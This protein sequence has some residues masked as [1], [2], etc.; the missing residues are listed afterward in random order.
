VNPALERLPDYPFARLRALLA[1]LEPPAGVEPV[2]MSI[3][4][5]QHPMP[6]FAAEILARH[7]GEWN[8]YPPI[9]G[10]EAWRQAT[11]RWLVRRFGLPDSMIDPGRMVAPL[12]GTREGL[13]RVAQLLTEG[14][15]AGRNLRPAIALPDPYYAPYGGAAVMAGAEPVFLP[16]AAA[17]GFLP[18]LDALEAD[19]P[20][21]ER[22]VLLYVCNP[23]NPQGALADAG[24]LD[25]L[26]GL[27][28]RH[29]FVVAADECYAEIYDSNPPVSILEAAARSGGSLANLLVFHSLS[30]RS[31]A[32]GLRSGFLVG[33]P[34]LV[35]GY[36]KIANHAAASVPLPIQAAS[37]ALWDDDAHVVENRALYR[38]KFDAAAQALA[39][40]FG[41]RRPPG[42]F[43]LWLDVGDGEAAARRLWVEAGLRT[44]PGA[45]LSSGRD[46]AVGGRYLRV[47]VVHETAIVASALGRFRAVLSETSLESAA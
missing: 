8:R 21:L 42:G 40:G 37:A 19:A 44:L 27:A 3:G 46:P 7:A 5:P 18:D 4:E 16:A 28:R 10:T 13:F 26:L 38:L 36:L 12:S 22:L 1:G 43:F 41:F 34:A 15:T 2:T 17:T 6:A 23:S 39:G 9:G 11:V 33:D 25:R 24:Y 35:A 14:E 30:K 20:L 47:A 31:N 29:G 45:Y 32:A